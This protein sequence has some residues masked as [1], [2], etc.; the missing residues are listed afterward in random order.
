M[1]HRLLKRLVGAGAIL[2]SASMLMSTAPAGANTFSPPLG[3]APTFFT[4]TAGNLIRTGGSETSYYVMQKIGDLYTQSSIYGCALGKDNRTCTG[5]DGT[6]TTNLDNYSRSEFDNGLG[7]GTGGGLKVLCD[8]GGSLPG[9]GGSWLNFSRGS[10]QQ[11]PN[12]SE[13]G[14][15]CPS[16][17][18]Q[19]TINGVTYSSAADLA[20][21]DDEVPGLVFPSTGQ[22]ALTV[23]N[24]Q[25]IGPVA[26]GWQPGDPFNCGTGGAAPLCSGNPV[27]LGAKAN[28]VVTPDI[29]NLP[30]P[31]ETTNAAISSV[32]Y[33][34]FCTTHQNDAT[35]PKLNQITDWGQLTDPTATT[36]TQ[37]YT[38]KN[39]NTQTFTPTKGQE[40]I[41]TPI[42]VPIYIPQVNSGSGT[43]FSF[44]AFACGLANELNSSNVSN[45]TADPHN[46]MQENN[47]PQLEDIGLL[48]GSGTLKTTSSTSTTFTATTATDSAANFTANFAG[49]TIS[50]GISSGT[51]ASNTTT[52]ITLA[53]AGWAGGTPA[54]GTTFTIAGTGTADYLAKQVSGEVSAL[55]AKEASFF[56]S[57]DAAGDAVYAQNLVAAS[58]Y[59]VSLGVSAATPFAL[60]GGRTPTST[61][62]KR[63]FLNYIPNGGS[64]ELPSCGLPSCN[65]YPTARQLHNFINPLAA[66]A[67]SVGFLNWLC[68]A[69]LS[70]PPAAHGLDQ[71]NGKN[72]ASE[73]NNNISTIF[74]FPREDC[75]NSS[76]GNSAALVPTNKTTTATTTS[77]SATVAD[78]TIKPGDLG[79]LVSGPGIPAG[80]I[81]GNVLDGVS[82]QIL[83]LQGSAACD[84]THATDC[85]YV[86]SNATA[87]GTG[88][89][90]TL[91]FS[92]E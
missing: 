36:D 11:K 53:G 35:D 48:Q 7:I 85:T 29:E 66:T 72:Y 82:F 57:S 12:G 89:S 1:K 43:T 44:G 8:L 14:G 41:G 33:R 60:V 90:L 54:A 21:A 69:D 86:P 79:A 64:Q 83:T 5:A 38:D 77:G 74:Q 59:F 27:G 73:L 91:D 20:F 47:A 23:T 15:A 52:T 22:T 3:T 92:K 17:A 42:G 26:N 61:Q 39:G 4:P 62:G 32:A 84:A 24:A 30:M 50:D 71:T 58:V 19:V 78:T 2:V 65:P 9:A 40:G 70:V 81:V 63:T 49:A 68:N 16:A 37:T 46:I 80:A 28:G 76:N 25:Q 6:V 88:V 10:R 45:T 18:N 56:P 13:S 55:Q 67:S 75:T 34:L 87:S 31:G 51:V